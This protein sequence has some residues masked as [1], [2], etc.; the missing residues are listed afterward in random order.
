[1]KFL[2]IKVFVVDVLLFVL[3]RPKRRHG[4]NLNKR[5]RES[6]KKDEATTANNIISKGW[7][8]VR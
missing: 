7:L 6:T 3:F 2:I 1:M 8:E 5:E 4:V